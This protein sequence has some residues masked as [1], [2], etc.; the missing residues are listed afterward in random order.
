[1]KND[2]TKNLKEITKAGSLENYIFTNYNN[3]LIDK[4][5]WGGASSF[6]ER[7]DVIDQ[8]YANFKDEIERYVLPETVIE[9]YQHMRPENEYYD[10]G[11]KIKQFNIAV[12]E[13][14][15][16]M[17]ERYS[18]ISA[19]HPKKTFSQIISL[20]DS[21]IWEGLTPSKVARHESLRALIEKKYP[22]KLIVGLA[23]NNTTPKI[24]NE[25]ADAIMAKFSREVLYIYPESVDYNVRVGRAI[26]S[27]VQEIYQDNRELLEKTPNK[28]LIQIKKSQELSRA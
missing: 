4:A 3:N 16:R 15:R 28:T 19:A 8:F 25:M 27:T 21:K 10:E 18:T 26:L 13:I 5:L 14:M 6:I 17:R 24:Q 1:M 22:A 20:D 23:I 2:W 11:I 7:V 12:G 9:V